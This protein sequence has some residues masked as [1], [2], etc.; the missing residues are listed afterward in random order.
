MIPDNQSYENGKGF[1]TIIMCT[2][3]CMSTRCVRYLQVNKFRIY[4]L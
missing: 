1:F 2:V 3:Y 4:K